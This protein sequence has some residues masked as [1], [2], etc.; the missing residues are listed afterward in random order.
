MVVFLLFLLHPFLLLDSLG[1]QIRTHALSFAETKGR[2]FLLERID[3]SPD[4]LT[5]GQFLDIPFFFL[6]G[7]LAVVVEGDR[8]GIGR[9]VVLSLQYLVRSVRSASIDGLVFL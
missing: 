7:I 9:G 4:I 6:V 3:T 8:R 1:R 2:L 5:H